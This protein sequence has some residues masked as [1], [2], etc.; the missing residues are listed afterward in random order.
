VWDA[1]SR[2]WF[3]PLLGQYVQSARPLRAV[4]R[5]TALC[6]TA[7]AI[8]QESKNPGDTAWARFLLGFVRFAPVRPLLKHRQHRS[9][10]GMALCAPVVHVGPVALGKGSGAG[11][12]AGPAFH[13]RSRGEQSSAHGPA[14]SIAA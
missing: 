2:C 14:L 12:R 1:D 9:L 4:R 13:G 11:T 7:L 6:Q 5:N 3:F 8:S 10:N